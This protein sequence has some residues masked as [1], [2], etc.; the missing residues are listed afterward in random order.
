MPLDRNY[1]NYISLGSFCSVAMELERYGLRSASYPFDWL[2]SPF[3]GVIEAINS[4]FEALFDESLYEQS[5]QRLYVYRNSKYNFE[6]VH[7]FTKYKPLSSQFSTFCEKYNRRIN[8]FFEAVG[9]PTLFI[10]Y[11]S[12]ISELKWIEQNWDFICASVK[13][14]N[15]KNEFLFVANNGI[16]SNM[17]QLYNVAPDKNDSVSRSFFSANEMLQEYFSF[18]DCSLKD[19]NLARYKNKNSYVKK[20]FTLVPKVSESSSEEDFLYGICA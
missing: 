15:E 5:K 6:F 19:E 4:K 18:C 3:N 7:D 17:F 13:K 16:S 2:L 9:N 11:I 20:T 1:S 12:G 8:R 10:R 14:F